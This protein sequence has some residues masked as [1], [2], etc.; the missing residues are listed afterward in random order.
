VTDEQLRTA[1]PAIHWDTPIKIVIADGLEGWACRYC[2]AQVGL[3]AQDVIDGAALAFFRLP[4]EVL[5]HLA[6]EHHRPIG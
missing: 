3:K 6:R 2:I 1:F 5:V 4:V